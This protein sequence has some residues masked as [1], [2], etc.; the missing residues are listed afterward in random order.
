[1]LSGDLAQ[2]RKA[3]TVL[4]IPPEFGGAL[5]IIGDLFAQGI[6]LP[7]FLDVA[8]LFYAQALERAEAAGEDIIH[9]IIKMNTIKHT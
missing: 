8:C 7:S 9:I 4:G 1:L 5:E 3:A 6:K 2:F